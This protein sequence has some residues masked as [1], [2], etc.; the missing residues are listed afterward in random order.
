[1]GWLLS[2]FLLCF[3]GLT[4]AGQETIQVFNL[5]DTNSGVLQAMSHSA[6]QS[7]AVSVTD[8]ELNGV[9]SSVLNAE[10]W[11]RTHVLAHF[12][13]TK[14]TTIVVGSGSIC[15][16]GQDHNLG[17]VLPSLRN[18]YHSLTRW[19]LQKDIEVSAVFSSGCLDLDS[20]PSKANLGEKFA[21]P[22]LEFLH[23]TN[24][25]YSINAPSSFSPSSHEIASLVSS[26]AE[27]VQKFV[28]FTLDKINVIITNPEIQRPM[29][30]KLSTIDHFPSR[31][32]PFPETAQPPLKSSV[33]FSVP[34]NTAKHPFPPLPHV[35]SPPTLSF[36]SA[37]P[38]FSFP[39]PAPPLS[40]P[41][42]SPPQM[43]HPF[44][45]EEPPLGGAATAPNYGYSLPPCN[46]AGTWAPAPEVGAVQKLWCVAKPSVPA[47]TLQVA[48]DYAC[49]EG[50][51]D[52]AEIKPQGRCFFPDTVVAHASYA[53]NS[54]WQKTKRNG[55]T[56]SFGGTAMIINADPS[57]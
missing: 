12:P 56:C 3:L 54:Y 47:D 53:F 31:P 21:K 10:T 50:G 44:A 32:A 2:F 30:R 40:F 14:I 19:G 26:H 25:T 17:L 52:C 15:Q 34:A 42:P 33:G 23:T 45:P 49:G 38:P 5:Y 46:P 57:E 24:S 11:L 29:N 35:A 13:A 22:L 9:S 4:G 55:G 43:S 8:D 37:S 16:G 48:M 20:T 39:H 51:A 41:H 27:F 18:L 36:P 6:G 28:P 1:M 7:F